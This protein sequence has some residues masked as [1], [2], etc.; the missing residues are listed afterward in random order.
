M[1]LP[2]Q[3]DEERDLECEIIFDSIIEDDDEH[4]FYPIEGESS[5]MTFGAYKC[6]GCKIHPISSAFP[7]DCYVQCQIPEDPLL[8][9]LPL[10]TCPPEFTPT[11]KNVKR[12]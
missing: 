2:R 11:Q 4:I 9:L 10:P 6:V 1:S 3:I 5:L 7:E 12:Y 8:S